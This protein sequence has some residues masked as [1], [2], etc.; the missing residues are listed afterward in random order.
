MTF[1]NLSMGSSVENVESIEGDTSI[2]W[3]EANVF[4]YSWVTAPAPISV[5][6]DDAS[7]DR[8]EHT[9]SDFEEVQ[10]LDVGRGDTSR[11]KSVESRI[12]ADFCEF[13]PRI[14]SHL[15][16]RGKVE[17]DLQPGLL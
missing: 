2:A 17:V 14:I 8:M 12:M 7:R 10:I 11:L 6:A 16:C 15:Q 1:G 9:T 13:S 4:A 5:S 3:T